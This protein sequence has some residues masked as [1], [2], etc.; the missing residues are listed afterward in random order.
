MKSC[1]QTHHHAAL[2][3][4]S[5][6]VRFRRD[7]P[8][9]PYHYFSASAWTRRI[10][11]RLALKHTFYWYRDFNPS[12]R[13]P[14]STTRPFTTARSSFSSINRP[15]SIFEHGRT[16]FHTEYFFFPFIESSSSDLLSVT[17]LFFHAYIQFIFP[18]EFT[19]Q[20]QGTCWLDISLGIEAFIFYLHD[21]QI[22]FCIIGTRIK[23]IYDAQLK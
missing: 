13:T 11:L 5:C 21:F 4:G 17:F 18:K 16:F 22:Y 20:R 19:L 14:S 15:C 7:N 10:S 6:I 23:L 8:A 9:A 2:S 12:S 3:P 1:N